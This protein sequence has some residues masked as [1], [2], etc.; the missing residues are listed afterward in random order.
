MTII[1]IKN[2]KKEIIRQLPYDS[3]LKT[4][5][6]TI[7]KM[8]LGDSYIIADERHNLLIQKFGKTDETAKKIRRQIQEVV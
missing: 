2:N 3:F 4:I 6:N 8:E 7:N 5:A 1:K